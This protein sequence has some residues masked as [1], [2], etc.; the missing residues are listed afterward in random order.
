M[1]DTIETNTLL[2]PIAENAEF[3]EWRKGGIGASDIAAI[4]GLSPWESPWSLWA[5]KVGLGE[6]VDV[7][8]AMEHGLW[9]EHSIVPWYE[10]RTGLFVAYPQYRAIGAEPW[11]RAT[12]DGIAYEFG[13]RTV[14]EFDEY[15][16]T[17]PAPLHVVECKATGDGPAKWD[18]EGIPVHYKAQAT[19]QSIVA[20]IDTVV[21]PVLHVPFGRVTFA[22][23]EHTPSDEDKQL[24]LDAATEF[25]QTVVNL[26]PPDV[27]AHPATSRAIKHAY[28][29]PDADDILFADDEQAE[30]VAALRD[31]KAYAKSTAERVTELENRI[32]ARMADCAYL[33]HGPDDL[34][35][36]K[37]STSRRVDLEALRNVGPQIADLIDEHTITTTT[38]RF[39]VKQAKGNT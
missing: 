15:H 36:W 30:L 17:G 24:V 38:R 37:P 13:G 2:P 27:D 32:K 39:L 16:R 1:T 34:V 25:W 11:M 33:R 26:E 23:Y 19:W 31:A 22:I 18:E 21:F 5:T 8:D 9:A 29:L 20:G 35:T 10:Q 4:L 3:A 12:V 7:T 6:P 14:D 28:D